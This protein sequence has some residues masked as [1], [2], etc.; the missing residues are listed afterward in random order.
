MED[1]KEIARV[2]NIKKDLRKKFPL[3]GRKGKVKG[4]GKWEEGIL[5]V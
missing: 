1:W 3:L 5:V 2:A 4:R